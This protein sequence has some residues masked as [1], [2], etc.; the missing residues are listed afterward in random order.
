MPLS[1]CWCNKSRS[2]GSKGS[3]PSGATACTSP[4][5]VRAHG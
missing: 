5:C 1:P 3:S 4:D 2:K